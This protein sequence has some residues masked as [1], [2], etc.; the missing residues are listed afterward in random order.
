[1]ERVAHK[2]IDIVGHGRYTLHD[3]DALGFHIMNL[4]N[5]HVR[6]NMLTLADAIMYHHANP[7]A[8]EDEYVQD[9]LF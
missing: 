7:F 1:M 3:I 9:S 8:E 5:Y 4:S 6:R 2:I